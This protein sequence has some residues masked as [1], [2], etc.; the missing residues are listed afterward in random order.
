MKEF[1]INKLNKLVETSDVLFG[2]NGDIKNF[3]LL[4][5]NLDY[6]GEIECKCQYI[7]KNKFFEKSVNL[8]I[9]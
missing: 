2:W 8:K 6:K 7:E 3:V 5:Y 1:L 4:D 9:I